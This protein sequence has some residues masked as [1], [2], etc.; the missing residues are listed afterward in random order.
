MKV[1]I[2]LLLTPVILL[3]IGWITDIFFP[4][5][6]LTIMATVLVVSMI[7]GLKRFIR[8]KFP[9]RLYEES[10]PEHQTEVNIQP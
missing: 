3:V 4:G 9:P 10:C 2:V 1:T 8:L 6:G 5:M 7:M